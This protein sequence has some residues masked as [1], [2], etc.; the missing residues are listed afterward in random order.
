MKNI[1]TW[2]MIPCSV[3]E[4]CNVSE[5]PATSIFTFKGFHVLKTSHFHAPFNLFINSDI[6]SDINVSVSVL[7][8]LN[9]QTKNYTALF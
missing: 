6:N 2:D 5:E 9:L 7:P 1:V 3:D 4:L 8:S